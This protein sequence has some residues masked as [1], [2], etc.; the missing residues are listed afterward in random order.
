MSEAAVIGVADAAGGSVPSPASSSAPTAP[1]AATKAALLAFLEPRV[2]RWSLPD[3]IV[4]LDHIPKTSVGKF[5]KRTAPPAGPG[6]EV[7]P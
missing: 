1:T 3:D 2:A 6:H 7:V 5:S 4:F